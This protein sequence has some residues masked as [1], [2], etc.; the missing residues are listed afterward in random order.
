MQSMKGRFNISALILIFCIV[1]SCDSEHQDVAHAKGVP[2]FR[3]LNIQEAE[4]IA[5][6]NG[7]TIQI[8]DSVSNM[9][10]AE[11]SIVQQEPLPNK[12][13]NEDKIVYL[14]VAVNEILVHLPDVIDQSMRS[15]ELQLSTHGFLLSRSEYITSSFCTNAVLGIKYNGKIVTRQDKIPEGAMITMVVTKITRDQ[16]TVPNLVGLTLREAKILLAIH[17]LRLGKVIYPDKSNSVNHESPLIFRQTPD[18]SP[19]DTIVPFKSKI[20]VFL[21][22]Q[23]VEK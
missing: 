18:T 23:K 22:N 3:N 21:K 16:A 15:A 8:S 1:I 20:N 19:S 2:D 4:A 17:E 7:L 11:S 12:K 13:A 10:V 14:T 9:E 5:T 6:S